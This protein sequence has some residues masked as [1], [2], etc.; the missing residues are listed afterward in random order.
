MKH[1]VGCRQESLHCVVTIQE[2]GQEPRPLP[3][4][5]RHSPRGFEWSYGGSGPADLAL[6]LLT[7]VAG[8]EVA[9]RWYQM[10]KHDVISQLPP[11]GWRIA[12]A[13]IEAWLPAARAGLHDRSVRAAQV[14]VLPLEPAQ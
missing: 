9:D 8:R 11:P 7:E 5:V 3:H 12:A 4:I 14:H 13:D 2:E 1:F 6:S 10:F